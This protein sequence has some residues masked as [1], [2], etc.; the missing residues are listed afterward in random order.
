[1]RLDMIGVKEIS[2]TGLNRRRKRWWSLVS[3]RSIYIYEQTRI[4]CSGRWH[5]RQI[6]ETLG[7]GG[8]LI[9]RKQRLTPVPQ[10]QR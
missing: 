4:A 3:Q 1:M 5:S 9:K 8:A 2:C 10:R 7:V 6:E